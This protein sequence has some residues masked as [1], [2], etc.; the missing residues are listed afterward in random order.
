MVSDRM[1]WHIAKVQKLSGAIFHIINADLP[2][3]NK[4]LI[5]HRSPFTILEILDLTS[6]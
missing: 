4:F 6:R 3:A 5:L 1:Q 2:R